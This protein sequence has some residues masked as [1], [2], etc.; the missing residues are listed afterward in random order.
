MS[1]QDSSKEIRRHE[2]DRI[3]EQVDSFIEKFKDEVLQKHFPHGAIGVSGY[4]TN[5]GMMPHVVD[6]SMHSQQYVYKNTD[7]Y[8]HAQGRKFLHYTKFS[9]L[10]EILKTKTIRLY[11]FNNFNDPS[12]YYF[13]QRLRSEMTEDI[14]G[15]DKGDLFAFSFN[16]GDKEDFTMWRLYGDDGLG[17]A[18]EFEIL[19]EEKQQDAWP[20][21][22][23]S[24]VKYN[25]SDGKL[26]EDFIDDCV[27]FSRRNNAPKISSIKSFILPLLG[28]L[29]REIYKG[30]NEV[31]LLSV[32]NDFFFNSLE[33]S[34]QYNYGLSRSGALVKYSCVP[35]SSQKEYISFINATSTPHDK[36]RLGYLPNIQLTRIILGYQIDHDDFERKLSILRTLLKYYNYEYPFTIPIV[37]SEFVEFFNKNNSK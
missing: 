34:P 5:A 15:D 33:G 18:F 12:E 31:R 17:A 7:F 30:E 20:C 22:Y 19:G 13:S 8:Y 16:E 10:V 4:K 37:P 6:V 23:L 36:R 2:A 29:K 28:S 27:E 35:I 1:D 21:H 25:D 3:E 9:N 24:K 11:D 26:I 14:T 32:K